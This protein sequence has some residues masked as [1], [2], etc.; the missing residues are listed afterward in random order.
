[1]TVH[2]HLLD[3]EEISRPDPKQNTS[4]LPRHFIGR[5]IGF[6]KALP[7]MHWLK[8]MDEFW[9]DYEKMKRDSRRQKK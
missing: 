3:K 1:V 6:I 4:G 2:E 7:V 8:A 5:M 9:D